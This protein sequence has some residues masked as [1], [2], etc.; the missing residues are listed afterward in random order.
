MADK[1]LMDGNKLMW[2]SGRVLDWLSGKRIAPLYIDMGITKTCNIQ[3]KYCYYSVPENRTSETF[4]TDTLIAFLKDAASMGVKAIGFLGDGEPMVHP[5]VYEA[6][7]A[8]AEAGLDMAL[9]SNGLVLKEKGLED[10]LASLTWIRFN[11]AASAEKYE[12]VMGSRRESFGKVVS[13]IGKCVAIK[14]KNSLKVTIGLQLVLIEENADDIVP[15]ARLGK[16]LGVDYAVIKQC[17]ESYNHNLDLGDEDYDRF[18][19]LLREAESYS[20]GGYNVIVKWKKMRGRG[21]RGYDHCY[22]CEFLPQISGNGK[23]YNCGNFFGNEAFCA[24]DLT[25]ESF[26]DIVFGERY[27]EV[28]D[29]VKTEVNVHKV[30]GINCRQNEINEFLWMVKNPP[31]HVNFI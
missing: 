4:P 6:V 21:I 31:E 17:S 14:R 2:H 30:C 8:G 3:C 23:V 19:P 28:M 5:G 7:I 24:G 9:S 10:F 27:K 12:Q 15:F 16:D 25:K 29:R 1:Y 22:G 11:I 18:A 13:N 26:R 20:E